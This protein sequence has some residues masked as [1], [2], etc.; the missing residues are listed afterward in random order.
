M[1]QFRFSLQTSNESVTVCGHFHL[2]FKEELR[3][4]FLFTR[5]FLAT[6][7]SQFLRIFPQSKQDESLLEKSFFAWARVST[8]C[9]WAHDLKMEGWT[10]DDG[11]SLTVGGDVKSCLSSVF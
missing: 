8:P 5:D 11:M 7:S 2:M 10:P 4:T 6:Q 1:T 9:H 3:E